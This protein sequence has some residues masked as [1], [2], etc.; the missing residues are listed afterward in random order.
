[1]PKL[2]DWLKKAKETKLRTWLNLAEIDQLMTEQTRPTKVWVTS[3]AQG[4]MRTLILKLN[5]VAKRITECEGG[6]KDT[7]KDLL[8]D[9]SLVMENGPDKPVQISVRAFI[10]NPDHE[11]SD[12]SRIFKN[13]MHREHFV[14][15]V[16]FL[17][18][19]QEEDYKATRDRIANSFFK[20]F[21]GGPGLGGPSGP[22]ESHY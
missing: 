3:Q 13:E 9:C 5:S 22:S 2:E 8:I 10:P 14:E 20:K 18:D 21:L 11:L 12:L 1:M 7:L 15:D 6:S 4:G 19:I 17:I 16:M